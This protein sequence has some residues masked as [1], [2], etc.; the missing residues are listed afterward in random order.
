[1]AKFQLKRICLM[2]LVLAVVA[3]CA[4]FITH[5]TP[6]DPAR[7]ILGN[8]ATDEQVNLLRNQLGLDQPLRAQFFTWL[9]RV[10]R[11]DLG[12]SIFLNMP[13]KE[14]ILS[15]VEPTFLISL[16]PTSPQPG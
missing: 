10:I 3:L 4:F 9:G 16:W 8:Y 6:G 7:V 2:I 11:G 5:L 13:V 14:A 1:M 12:Q 15:R